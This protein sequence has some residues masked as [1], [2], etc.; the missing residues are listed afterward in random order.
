MPTTSLGSDVDEFPRDRAAKHQPT[1]SR[2]STIPTGQLARRIA[3][4]GLMDL[5]D[6]LVKQGFDLDKVGVTAESLMPGC[7]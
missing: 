1:S 4:D 2:S 5:K 6:L 3:Q 7:C